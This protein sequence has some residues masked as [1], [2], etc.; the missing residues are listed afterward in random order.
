LA[1]KGSENYHN[2][3]NKLVD[4]EEEDVARYKNPD[5]NN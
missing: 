4:E 5:I 1:K 3:A 2:L